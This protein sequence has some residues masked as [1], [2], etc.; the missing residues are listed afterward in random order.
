M[1]TECYVGRAFPISNQLKITKY[2]LAW[3]ARPS[4]KT[5]YMYK[6]LNTLTN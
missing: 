6:H 5:A 2:V 4:G 3:I 1:E